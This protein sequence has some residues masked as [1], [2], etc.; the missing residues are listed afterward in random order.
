MLSVI[1][2]SGVCYINLIIIARSPRSWY[3]HH[4][5]VS[6]EEIE[7]LSSYMAQVGDGT[8]ETTAQEGHFCIRAVLPFVS[9]DFQRLGLNET[10]KIQRPSCPS[11]S[12]YRQGIWAPEKRRDSSILLRWSYALSS[13]KI[14]NYMINDIVVGN[15][16]ICSGNKSSGHW[17]VL[18][19]V[20]RPRVISFLWTAELSTLS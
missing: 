6:D 2:F 14:C 18:N 7:R 20:T 4:L 3:C 17:N 8:T 11:L 13:R 5:H 1:S 12:H 19:F 15:V 16:S 9:T 10:F